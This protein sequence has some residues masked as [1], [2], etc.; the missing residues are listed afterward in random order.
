M[1]KVKSGSKEFDVDSEE[2]DASG[3]GV[4][5]AECAA[6]ATR[7]KTGEIS[8]VKTL[9]LVSCFVLFCRNTNMSFAARQPNR[10]R[11]SE[12]YCC[13]SATEQQRADAGPCKMNF[14][15]GF[16][17]G[18][19]GFAFSSPCVRADMSFAGPQ[20]NRRRGS[21]GYC[22]RSATEQQG[23]DAVPCKMNFV[24]VFY[25]LNLGLLFYRRA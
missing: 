19:F 18:E 25:V 24:V 7:M 21:D 10:R 4:S 9:V 12:G 5:D 17:C 23:A 11:G 8:R 1:A 16:L 3:C 6:F 20:P 15:I 2:I 22:C 13:R 14:V